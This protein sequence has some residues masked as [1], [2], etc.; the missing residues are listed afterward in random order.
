MPD[1][2][3]LIPEIT[4]DEIDNVC[5]L[6]GLDGVDAPRRAFLKRRTTVDVSACPGSGKTML[7]VA[8]L[9]ILASK[10]PHRT[11]G[12]CVLSHTN[13]AREQIEHRL[14]R[15]V[16]GQRLLS[17]PHFIDTIHG[18]VNRFLALPWLHSNGYP[19]PTIDDDVTTSYRRSV[20]GRDYYGVEAFLSKKRSGFD[21]LRL[22]DRHMSF[23]LGGKPF[24]A[25]PSAKS[26]QH[27]QT[28]DQGRRRRRV[29]LLRRN[30]RLGGRPS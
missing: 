1:A 8:K 18:F 27:A 9:A 7:I 5:K 13:V 16:V 22:S 15:S 29:F 2:D 30:V 23:D 4:D 10:W 11:Q 20:L 17:Y 6:M 19:S 28:R 25:G 21:R 14:G 3:S 24:P 12:I 26:H